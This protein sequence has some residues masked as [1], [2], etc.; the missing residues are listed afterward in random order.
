VGHD[1]NN[2]PEVDELAFRMESAVDRFVGDQNAP[3]SL[4]QVT[5]ATDETVGNYPQAAR[6]NRHVY[7]EN[8]GGEYEDRLPKSLREPLELK[9]RPSAKWTDVLSSDFWSEGYMLSDRALAVF[10]RF[11]LGRSAQYKAVVAGRREQRPYTYLFTANHITHDDIDFPRSEFYISDMIG[12][13]LQLIEIGSAEEFDQKR[14]QINQGEM[15]GFK[16]FSGLR[17]KRIQLKPGH[18]PQAAIFGLGTFGTD[19]Y[20]RRELYEALRDAGV[21][22]LEFKRNN[23]VFE[24]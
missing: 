14:R 22:G 10:D 19:M 5:F 12:T 17:P 9:L 3:Q 2:M 1:E 7:L 4:V 23:K 8:D 16:R 6:D 21:T 24:D 20:V 15:E 13:P 11:P 18:A